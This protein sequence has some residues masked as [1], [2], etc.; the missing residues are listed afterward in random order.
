MR[1]ALSAAVGRFPEFELV[2][3]RKIKA[4]QTFR[5]ICEGLAEAEA[6]LSRVEQF[7]P[8][9]RAA[10]EAEWRDIIGRLTREMEAALQEGQAAVRSRIGAPRCR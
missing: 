1:A 8:H 3:R 4:D 2:I 9:I 10:R 7:P 5:D 6:A